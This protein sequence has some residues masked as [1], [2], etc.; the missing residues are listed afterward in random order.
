MCPHV[1]KKFYFSVLHRYFIEIVIFDVYKSFLIF[2]RFYEFWH[3]RLHEN[4]QSANEQAR[5]GCDRFLDTA[6][7][8][9]PTDLPIDSATNC[10]IDLEE[11]LK[12][13][14]QNQSLQR[15]QSSVSVISTSDPG[16]TS[17]PTAGNRHRRLIRR[18][19]STASFDRIKGMWRSLS[20]RSVSSASSGIG[21]SIRSTESRESGEE[22]VCHFFVAKIAQLQEFNFCSVLQSSG[23]RTLH[24]C[25]HAESFKCRLL[26][27]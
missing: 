23:A 27:L 5:T 12:Q 21:G 18:E 14:R 7:P 3:S 22:Q 9:L 24:E 8:F 15:S 2:R 26:K 25:L 16:Q 4:Y 20:G 10:T 13:D 17:T 6:N 1:G 19:E 11:L